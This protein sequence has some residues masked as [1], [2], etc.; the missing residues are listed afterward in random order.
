MGG[1]WGRAWLKKEVQIQ[2]VVPESQG[3]LEARRGWTGEPWQSPSAGIPLVGNPYWAGNQSPPTNS[4]V[5]SFLEISAPLCFSREITQRFLPLENRLWHVGTVS[6]AQP[7]SESILCLE[8]EALVYLLPTIHRISPHYR[9]G[10]GAAQALLNKTEQKQPQ[11]STSSPAFGS[12]EKQGCPSSLQLE[13][14]TQFHRFYSPARNITACQWNPCTP[15]SCSLWPHPL[16]PV[17]AGL[18]T[19]RRSWS[20]LWACHARKWALLGEWAWLGLCGHSEKNIKRRSIKM[21]R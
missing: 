5:S 1:Q 10:E 2:A 11:H 16:S 9:K 14:L 17:G 18:C 19:H 20:M 21:L 13:D 12:R 7:P 3:F 8:T 6:R 15:D 4:S